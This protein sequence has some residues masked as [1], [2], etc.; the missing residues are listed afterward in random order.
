MSKISGHKENF[1]KFPKSEVAQPTVERQNNKNNIR[2]Q[3]KKVL[4]PDFLNSSYRTHIPKRVPKI[5]L[6]KMVTIK[7]MHL[8]T[9]N[10]H[11]KQYSGKFTA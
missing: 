10:R 3:N 2:K 11:L 6:Q 7:I 4:L 9:Y 5:T 1:N 8:R